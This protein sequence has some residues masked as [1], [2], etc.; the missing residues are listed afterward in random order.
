MSSR[1]GIRE[2]TADSRGETWAAVALRS[3][4][5]SRYRELTVYRRARTLADA[6]HA[7]SVQWDSFDQWTVGVQLVRAADSVGAN[8]AEAHGRGSHADQR[9]MLLIAR[10]S[11][12]EVEHWL[13]TAVARGLVGG[14]DLIT[15]IRDIARMVNAMIARC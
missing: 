9:R 4:S 14:S 3:V 11:V 6:V 7:L 10:G 15:E 8:I 1:L 2:Q 13:D 5:G 12:L